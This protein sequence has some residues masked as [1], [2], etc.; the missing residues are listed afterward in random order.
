LAGF[1][2]AGA[3]GRVGSG[4][5]RAGKPAAGTV[6][7]APPG[8]PKLGIGV[9]AAERF[10]NENE[11]DDDGPSAGTAGTPRAGGGTAPGGRNVAVAE[12]A[13]LSSVNVGSGER[14]RIGANGAVVSRRTTV[15]AGCPR[16]GAPITPKL[17]G[18]RVS[19]G[20]GA[21]SFASRLGLLGI[22]GL[23]R[24][25]PPDSGALA[26]GALTDGA[27]G[28]F[29][30]GT[31]AGGTFAGG[32]FAVGAAAGGAKLAGGAFDFVRTGGGGG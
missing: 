20:S 17:L 24:G 5:S 14:P 18:A 31:F 28:V 27:G 25:S 32:T 6:S 8:G 4:A 13:V 16:R 19:F 7:N 21:P 3:A 22:A 2:G 30:G 15:A 10:S 29:A 23:S 11:P 9:I 26:G 1:D 12:G